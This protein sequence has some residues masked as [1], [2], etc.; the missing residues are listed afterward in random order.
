MTADGS[1]F[2]G[3]NFNVHTRSSKGALALGS[4][5]ILPCLL[6]PRRLMPMSDLPSNTSTFTG[7]MDLA[8]ARVAEMIFSRSEERRVGKESRSRWGRY[9]ENQDEIGTS[10]SW[11]Q[12]TQWYD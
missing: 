3:V 8:A 9:Y 2:V 5:V 7:F 6:R 1:P 11:L 12:D 10:V 4:I